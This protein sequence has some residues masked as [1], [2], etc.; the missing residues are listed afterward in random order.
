MMAPDT[1]ECP[2]CEARPHSLECVAD[3]AQH[4]IRCTVCDTLGPAAPTPP[5]AALLWGTRAHYPS[6]IA[7]AALA[8]GYR[9]G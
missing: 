8:N 6:A 2:F 1:P 5:G 4:R 9:T 7:R 3:G